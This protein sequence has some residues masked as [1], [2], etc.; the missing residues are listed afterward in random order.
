[1]TTFAWLLV[2]LSVLIAIGTVVS[3]VMVGRVLALSPYT[4][5]AAPTVPPWVQEL[6]DRWARKAKERESQLGPCSCDFEE[7]RRDLL[8]AARGQP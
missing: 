6:A 4:T 2:G 1:M 8:A 3:V 7:C 5:E